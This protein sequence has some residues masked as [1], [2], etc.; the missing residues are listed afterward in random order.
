VAIAFQPSHPWHFP[1]PK[2]NTSAASV[3][4]IS[5]KPMKPARLA[6]ATALAFTLGALFSVASD[7]ALMHKAEAMALSKAQS[8]AT[9]AMRSLSSTLGQWLEWGEGRIVSKIIVQ[10]DKNHD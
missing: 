6:K 3:R 5:G 10:G 4:A 9:T 7:P 2:R 1:A 8:I